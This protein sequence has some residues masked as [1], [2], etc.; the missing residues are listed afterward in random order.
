MSSTSP[1]QLWIVNFQ[2]WIRIIIVLHKS[3]AIMNSLA[4]IWIASPYLGRSFDVP[5]TFLRRILNVSWIYLLSCYHLPSFFLP[6]SYPL[7]CIYQKNI[8]Y[9]N[10]SLK[11]LSIYKFWIAHCPLNWF[12]FS[13]FNF[14]LSTH[15]CELSIV[16]CEFL[17]YY[18]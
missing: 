1:R 8:S 11:K 15:H 14:Q 4:T 3:S 17:L 13:I 2:L 5:T 10:C 12:D 7:F 9:H 18:V 16:N 6:S